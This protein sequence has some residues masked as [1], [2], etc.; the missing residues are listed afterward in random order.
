[1]CDAEYYLLRDDTARVIVSVQRV[2]LT[3]GARSCVIVSVESST[4]PSPDL[5]SAANALKSFAGTALT[6]RVA[7]LEASFK[8]STASDAAAQLTS[9]AVTHD[10]L[11]AAY[12]FKQ[13]AG[14][15]NV[16]IHAVGILLCLPDILV[17]GERVEY[18]SLGAGNT[19]KAFDL[20]TNLRVAEFKFIHWQGGPEVIRQNA[21]FKD[22]YL[23]AEHETTKLKFMYVLDTF[24][25]ARFLSSKRTLASVMSRNRKLWESFQSRY[26]TQFLTVSDYYTAKASEVKLAGVGRLLKELSAESVLSE[27][28]HDEE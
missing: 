4:M 26:G 3:P 7:A 28:E 27:A 22:V 1:M 2:R 17:A 23:L 11:N 21:L 18:L 8:G 13:V 9:D 20:E 6:S 14:Q 15:I 10:L 16:V 5:I 25:P 12:T 24:Y 19:G